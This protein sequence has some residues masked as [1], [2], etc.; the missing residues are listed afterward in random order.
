MAFGYG[1]G[2]LQSEL[3]KIDPSI[4]SVS[5]GS[6]GNTKITYKDG[7]TGTLSREGAKE[8]Q[9]KYKVPTGR[10]GNDGEGEE[11]LYDYRTVTPEDITKSFVGYVPPT[12]AFNAFNAASYDPGDVFGIGDF[13][14]AV[15]AGATRQNI[16]DIAKRA[17]VVGDR[18]QQLF[19]ELRGIDSRRVG[20]PAGLSP[21]QLSGYDV[22]T[23]IGLAELENL[24]NLGAT[25]EQVAELTNRATVVDPGLRTLF[26]KP[27]VPFAPSVP[28][29]NY[30]PPASLA[31]I[32][33]PTPVSLV[34]AAEAP[35]LAPSVQTVAGMKGGGLA[36]EARGL[37]AL[38]RGEDSMLV[39]MSPQEVAGLQALALQTGTS[40]TINPNTGLPEA[41]NLKKFLKAVVPIALGAF[42]G[43]GA[44]GIQGLGMSAGYAGLTVGGLT[45][46]AT[47]SLEKGLSAGLS[48]YG[49]AGLAEGAAAAST[50]AEQEVARQATLGT[51]TGTVGSGAGGVSAGTVGADFVGPGITGAGPTA[52]GFSFGPEGEFLIT[53]AEG[54]PLAQNA[55]LAQQ[56]AATPTPDYITQAM[57]PKTAALTPMEAFTDKFGMG[58]AGS[59][60]AGSVALPETIEETEKFQRQQAALR[61]EED[62]K[63][64]LYQELFASTLGQ[65]PVRT[66]RQGGLMSLAKGGM[67]YMEAGG[68]TGL[69]GVPR[70]VK[71]TGDGMSDS[72]PATIEGVQEA[73]LADGEFVIPADVVADIGNGSSGAGSK[74]LY[75][76]MDRIR[77]ARHG[78]TEQPPEINA[79]ALMPA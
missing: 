67:T 42:L 14:K 31:A 73:R 17:P 18:M 57:A 45:A 47:G 37:A 34:Q 25:P 50:A 11:Y 24:L 55:T 62:E 40:L 39:H 78:T 76:M 23:G 6:D 8:L 59:L 10:M 43:P 4:K 19:P 54:A 36:S 58:T 7:T 44:F 3:R 48:A 52:S 16:L 5:T 32:A 49:G 46:L 12:E 72:V 29:F 13:T 61:A 15:N 21:E 77:K 1:T 33:P 75:D 51:G 56:M 79:E 22:S 53:G 38:G 64:R 63:K 20:L 30:A 41:L 70:D 69:T 9:G 65:V 26:P 66:A 68:T 35:A 2:E 71:G 27:V 60:Y 28:E 74:K